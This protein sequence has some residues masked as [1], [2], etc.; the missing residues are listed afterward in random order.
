[1]VATCQMGEDVYDLANLGSMTERFPRLG[2]YI[3]AIVV[4]L[5]LLRITTYS[6]IW[7]Y[8]PHNLSTDQL[9]Q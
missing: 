3:S 9:S 8:P 7:N 6:C 2:W 1:M 4:F 5:D